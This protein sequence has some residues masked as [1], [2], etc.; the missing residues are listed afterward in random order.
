MKSLKVLLTLFISCLVSLSICHAQGREISYDIG[1]Q[2]FKGYLATP[3]GSG[4]YPGVVIIHE[5]W[6]L[7]DYPRLRA[8]QLARAGY[9]AL[10]IDMYGDGQTAD[11]PSGATALSSQALSDWD[12]VFA[13]VQKGVDVLKEQSLVDSKKVAAIGYC[14]GG[15]VVVNTARMGLDVAAIVSFHGNLAPKTQKHDYKA[16]MLILNGAADPLVSKEEILGFKNEMKQFNIPYEFVDYPGAKH[17]F[18]NPNATKIGK[19]FN[20]PVAYNQS[21]DQKSWQKMLDFFKETFK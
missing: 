5:W 11:T 9:V 6:G 1:T 12:Q 15:G 17:A 20:L 14:F 19:K 2:K 3:D 21:A 8:D 10:A 4:P 16:K 18:T 13:R 7:N